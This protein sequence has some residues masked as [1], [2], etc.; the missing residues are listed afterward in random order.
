MSLDNPVI[1]EATSN[2]VTVVLN[3]TLSQIAVVQP[4]VGST[5]VRDNVVRGPEGPSGPSGA[6]S[7]WTIKTANY[8]AVDGDRIVA[9]TSNGSFTITLP[10]SPIGGAYVQFTD[11]ASWS[12]NNLTVARNGSTIEGYSQDLLLNISGVTVECIYNSSQNTW[13]VTATL[14]PRGPQG[15]TGPSVTGPQGPTG[16][17]GPASTDPG[18]QGPQG[19]TGPTGPTGDIGPQGPA[20]FSGVAGPQGPTG[21]SGPEGSFGGITLEYTFDTNTANT[22]PGV[23][24]LKF[25]QTNLQLAN[26]L[27]ISEF[28]D[29]GIDVTN[30][31]QTIDDS[32][33][34]IKG[35]FK[36]TSRSNVEAFILYTISSTVHPGIYSIVNCSYVSGD[37]DLSG[38]LFTENQNVLVT[39]ART[40][41]IGAPGPQGPTGPTGN[42]VFVT[43]NS[44][45]SITSNTI[46]FVNTATITVETS[47]NSGIV[48]VAFTSVGGSGSSL[49]QLNVKQVF[50]STNAL[51]NATGTITHDC[52]NGHIF[53]HSTPSANFTANFT[54]AEV[55]SN[56]ATAFTLVINQGA[57]AYV[58]T[59]V[60]IANNAQTVNWQGGTQ[61]AGNPNKKDV[62]T[63]SVINNNGT[64]ITLGQLTSYG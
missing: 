3:P 47:N 55:V 40:G 7:P 22:D 18:P 50:E 12:N 41:D 44:A 17:T 62:V 32:T 2:T 10:S 56:N 36:V 52:I 15:P 26:Q 42:S 48:N 20:G 34:P 45:E 63:F 33:S 19:P 58:P 24:Q 13:E 61:P 46:N 30:F 14:G 60:Q 35:H 39:F 16:P 5:V 53:V 59:A 51:T 49:Q 6:L 31:L 11:G 27:Y 54:N 1:V 23:G 57:T 64:W 37:T 38:I 28:A 21:P 43:A 29:G 4:Q 9:D 25:N 8:T